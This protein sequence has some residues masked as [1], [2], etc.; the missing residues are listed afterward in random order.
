MEM[1]RDEWAEDERNNSWACPCSAGFCLSGSTA[2][3][4]STR[5]WVNSSR[6]SCLVVAQKLLRKLTESLHRRSLPRCADFVAKVFWSRPAT[7]RAERDSYRSLVCGLGFPKDATAAKRDSI[8]RHIYQSSERLLQQNL[9]QPDLPEEVEHGCPR[10]LSGF[11]VI[12]KPPEFGAL[13]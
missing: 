3:R 12:A 9:P 11:G 5:L 13:R 4:V 10:C 8:S 7:A 1:Q 6:A 2:R